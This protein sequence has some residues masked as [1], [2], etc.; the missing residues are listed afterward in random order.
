MPAAVPNLP[1]AP[2]HSSADRTGGLQSGI[3]MHLSTSERLGPYEIVAPIGAG[4]MGEV[5]RAK[6]TRLDRTVA[7]KVLPAHLAGN[8]ELRQRLERE[9]KTVSSLNHS[10]ICVLH[11]IGH[12]DG[13]DY[14]VMEYLEGDTLAARLAKG[15]LPLE[16]ALPLAIQITD[17]LE[18]AHRRSVVHRDLK[19]ANIMLTRSGAKLLD[20]G[21][22]RIDK[23]IAAEGAE[24][25]TVTAGLTNPGTILGTFQYMAP[26]QLEGKD[27]DARTDL[28]AFGAVLYEMLTG[29]KAFEGQSQASL[30]SAIMSADPPAIAALQPLT[31]PALERVVNNCLAKDPDD[32]W[33]SAH[34]VKLELTWLDQG[35]GTSAAVPGSHSWERVALGIALALLVAAG[36]LLALN[37]FRRGPQPVQT[38]RS[39]ILPPSNYFFQRGNF[40]ISPDGTRL[41]FTAVG[42]DGN[43]T[44]WVR[45]FSAGRAQQL[46]GTGGAMFPFWAPD[47]RRIGFFA[48]GKLET[49]DVGSGAVRILCEAPLGRCG[50]AW[51]REGTIVFAP[52]LTGPLY[53]I[54][55]SGGAPAPVTTIARPGSGQRH[56]WPF[57]LPD[58]GHF[59][60]FV[61][62]ST[63]DDPQGNGVYVGSLD[64]SRPKLV[65]SELTGNVAFAGGYLLYGR[66]RSLRA[67]PFD[68]D[69]LQPT[70]SVVSIAEQELEEDAGFSH[71]EFSVSTNGVLVFQSMADSVSRLMWFDQ[72]GKELGQIA[73]LGY[74]DPRLSP[75]G[76]FL[77]I[78][79]DDGRNGKLFVRVYDL[80]R[81]IA[82]RL[83]EGASDESPVWS[84]D[85][86][87]IAY[88]AFDGKSHYVKSTSA[89]GSGSPQVLLNGPAIMRHLDWSQDGRLVFS[90]FSTGLPSLRVYPAAEKQ[91]M[92]FARGAEARFSPDAK[93]VAYAGSGGVF[94][95]P[96]PGPGGRIEISGGNGAQPVWAR[97]GR[98]IFYIASDRKLMA[99][100]FD[101]K[102]KSAGAP[103]VLFQTRIIAPNFVATQYDVSADGRFLINSVPSNYSSPL[104]LLTGW[105]AQLKH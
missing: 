20:F 43:Y 34:D 77:A 18:A 41:A 29:R 24:G 85:G 39:S 13:I 3:A 83:T 59:L 71:S 81:G 35:G 19:P 48:D 100:S 86:A 61:D 8:P 4:G 69:R 66:D 49:V 56:T 98:Q 91:A 84:H 72:G 73:E 57:F 21:L 54:P 92:P 16:Q 10:H 70:G 95:Q 68:P 74:K 9:A 97:D 82:T 26:E 23:R 38:V 44:L 60:Y 33:Q 76:R 58:G 45:T 6:D 42:P 14:L 90:D 52:S 25:H 37:S 5:Y 11:D 64:A 62:W 104:T 15:P 101:P 55:D 31:P 87:K 28:F 103:R 12:Q 79:S 40:S 102:R 30:I 78:S 2:I 65:S 1:D 96:F 27:A 17:A 51:N 53:R 67:Q 94:A 75:D 89:D 32:R 99:V 46:S 50:G 36:V 47:S 80:A 22:A 93:W 63:A 88:G 105:T 7:I